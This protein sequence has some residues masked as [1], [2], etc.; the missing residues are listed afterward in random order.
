MDQSFEETMNRIRKDKEEIKKNRI[1]I[2][3]NMAAIDNNLIKI[4]RNIHIIVA[5]LA[6]TAVLIVY[7]LLETF[8]PAVSF[9]TKSST[10]ICV[11]L[12]DVIVWL[13]VYKVQKSHTPS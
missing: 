6:A 4:D 9:L 3:E 2:R 13:V 5:N 10:L 8:F 7:Y 1:A 11:L 12:L